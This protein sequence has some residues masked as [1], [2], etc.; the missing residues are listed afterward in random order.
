M[1][2]LAVQK[3][4]IA[5][6]KASAGVQALLGSPVPIF[7]YVPENTPPAY[8]VYSEMVMSEFNTFT[9]IG[10]VHSIRLSC[11]SYYEGSKVVR[12]VCEAL[13]ELLDYQPL[14]LDSSNAILMQTTSLTVIQTNDKTY[15]G[16]LD[17]NV[18]TEQWS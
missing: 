10:G 5:T 1:S 8:L 6:I 2:G 15:V 18:L 17:L 3:A 14:T 7:E 12:E 11:Y 9:D 16:M 13:R 4:I